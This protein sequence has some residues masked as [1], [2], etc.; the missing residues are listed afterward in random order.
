MLK[1]ECGKVCDIDFTE[2]GFFLCDMNEE[3]EESTE[4]IDGIEY[5]KFSA[6]CG[7]CGAYLESISYE[8]ETGCVGTLYGKATMRL[9]EETL[10]DLSGTY[11]EEYH[12]NIVPLVIKL[13]E[14]G[15][16][17][18]EITV[19]ACKDCGKIISPGE[20][21]L[22][23]LGCEM[24]DSVQSEETDENGIVRSVMSAACTVC[25]TELKMSQWKV[26]LSECEYEEHYELKMT[27]GGKTVFVISESERDSE[28]GKIV[29]TYQPGKPGETEA[30]CS[31]SYIVTETCSRCG[32]YYM[33]RDNG[34]DTEYV[35][36][37]MSEYTPCG[38][39]I[40]GYRCGLCGVFTYLETNAGCKLG[41]AEQSTITDEN[42][43]DHMLVSSSCSVCGLRYEGD[44]YV[45][46]DGPCRTITVTEYVLGG[47][48]VVLSFT[49]KKVSTNHKY[50]YTYILDGG[51]CG[52]GYT[53]NEV[54]TV[55][56]EASSW[57]NSG[58]R[59]EYKDI[60]LNEYDCCGGS[61]AYEMCKICGNIRDVEVYSKCSTITEKEEFTDTDGKEKTREIITCQKCGLEIVTVYYTESEKSCYFT[62]Y[63]TVAVT[64]G[65]TEIISGEAIEEYIEHDFEYTVDVTDGDCTNGWTATVTCAECGYNYQDYG[66]DHD[67][68]IRETYILSDYGVC[69]GTLESSICPCGKHSSYSHYIR[70]DY[71]YNDSSYTENGIEYETESYTCNICNL[72]LQETVHKEKVEGECLV[73]SIY[74]VVLTVN[75]AL[76]LNKNFTDVSAGH[77]YEISVRYKNPAIAVSCEDGIIVTHTCKDC[78]YSYD[79]EE[80]YCYTFIAEDIDLADYGCVCGGRLLIERCLCGKRN[81]Y[82]FTNTEC[83]LDYA[84][85]YNWEKDAIPDGS[86]NVEER[87]FS[88]YCETYT[89]SVT[90]PACGC[91]YFTGRYWKKV[92]GKC[93]AE[94]YYVIKLGYD[95][96]SGSCQREIVI[97]GETEKYHYVEQ[98]DYSERTEN[99]YAVSEYAYRCEYCDSYRL[100][101]TYYLNDERVKYTEECR[102]YNEDG[103]SELI[104]EEYFYYKGRRY[105]SKIYSE[106]S[107]D[108]QTE[109]EKR[110][111]EYDFA[112]G[113]SYVCR[114]TSS[115]GYSDTSNGTCHYERNAT[116][117]EPTCTQFGLNGWKCTVCEQVLQSTVINPVAHEWDILPDKT[118]YC[119][120]CGLMNANGA[121][122]AVVMEDFTEQYGGDYYVV[123][124][125]N[126]GTVQYIYSVGIVPHVPAADGDDIIILDGI[127]V[128]ERTDISAVEFSK[129]AVGSAAALMGYAAGTYDV[130]FA[131]VPLGGDGT[132]DYA[133]T[134]TEP[135]KT[136]TE[137]GLY[138]LKKD[139]ASGQA[140]IEIKT[141]SP[142]VVTVISV[143]GAGDPYAVLKDGGGNVIAGDD[144]S[145]E[146]MNFALS[147]KCEPGKSYYL[148]V[149]RLSGAV[150]VPVYVSFGGDF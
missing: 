45:V 22:D 43:V 54:C 1:C 50:E 28:H 34:H 62:E 108:G 9:G 107:I 5:E 65:G 94:R 63:R 30:D 42:G 118:Y 87:Y 17:G 60:S 38:G 102:L 112:A 99:G 90:D 92:P 40:E 13:D 78:G 147:A 104:T 130:R 18:G 122:G 134:L 2:R 46:N 116:I 37:D 14:Y 67:E 57:E 41:D 120:I 142:L 7:I 98:S 89:C 126:R 83:D 148:T 23:T 136:I 55:C 10:F 12:G 6:V 123:G 146:G 61:V 11:S 77:D 97:S 119:V 143:A 32:M 82:S 88:N 117:K 20:M 103:S 125:W 75:D 124:Y 58:H 29:K 36:I 111:Y 51:T 4:I 39:T 19:G 137:P 139:A 79:Y 21:S 47:D 49:E 141:N 35:K 110:E 73:K 149:S 140:V 16:C 101:K 138:L 66:N 68:F 25:G 53:V 91:C 26:K 131:F 44:R 93:L 85:R 128:T 84:Y 114:Y 8:G 133:V 24:G 15:G 3:Y 132:L 145:G 70:C 76:V 27:A 56:G 69:G 100:E 72:R 113:C 109:W 115:G 80:N 71:N 121:S 33:Y 127:T 64:V 96:E 31:G 59:Y 150:F 105:E 95:R 106:R 129:S 74:A 135:E 52:D 48:G 86:D 81:G 144:D